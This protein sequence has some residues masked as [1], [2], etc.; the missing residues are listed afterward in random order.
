MPAT[1]SSRFSLLLTIALVSVGIFM[2]GAFVLFS[3]T[4]VHGTIAR[5]INDA[6]DLTSDIEPPPLY[7]IEAMVTIHELDRALDRAP[8]LARF[9]QLKQ[10][11]EASEKEWSVRL[12]THQAAEQQAF[13]TLTR[14]AHDFFA[15]VERELMPMV[16]RNDQAGISA[17]LNGSLTK[18]FEHHH[19]Q[20]LR[21]MK[22]LGE[23]RR[24]AEDRAHHV[25]WVTGSIM[26]VVVIALL[27]VGQGLVKIR[28]THQR[29]LR[30]REAHFRQLSEASFEG[31]GISENGVLVDANP[32]LVRMLGYTTVSDIIG[33]KLS[34]FIA[35]SCLSEFL[36]RIVA[37]NEQDYEVML[38]RLDGSEIYAEVRPRYCQIEDRKLR[39]SSIRDITQRKK[40]EQELLRHRDHLEEL[41]VER[42]GE[43]ERISKEAERLQHEAESARNGAID[44][45]QEARRM[46]VSYLNAK[47]AA[48]AANRAK[49]EF[50]ASM[51][52][53]IRTP[54]NAVLGYAQL[55]ARDQRL[56]PDQLRAV[57]VINRSGSHL[58]ALISDILDMSR[59]ESGRST[60]HP[61]DFDLRDLLDNLKS[62]FLIRAR[63][64]RLDLSLDVADVLPQF[65]RSDQRMLRQIM[66]NLLSNAVK[67]TTRGSVEILADKVEGQ[68]TI[69]VRDSGPGIAAEDLAQLF[70]PFVQVRAGRGQHEGSGLGLAISRGFARTIGG[71]IMAASEV[72]H[73]SNFT[74]RIP[75]VVAE[76]STRMASSGREVIGLAPGSVPPRIL[77]A[78]DH[79]D[80]QRL[81]CDLLGAAGLEVRAVHDGAAAV[82]CCRE[83]ILTWCGWISTCPCWT[84]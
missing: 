45:L 23:A 35:Q 55:L 21:M 2:T 27:L 73:G 53:E 66:M 16:Q 44:A 54:L 60:A 39:V 26:V 47:D 83:G 59:I 24:N 7:L 58:L 80:N 43:L 41:I 69:S 18:T 72:G 28:M 77:I 11:Y 48:E 49:S 75:L 3:Q 17:A 51:S 37:Q 40:S 31:I 68:L 19:E 20:V 57:Q 63:D 10:R 6:Q 78:E 70:Q 4:G 56:A 29:Q 14:S 81:L 33:R 76:R 71:D 32:Q 67:F 22:L 13:A 5:E 15:A 79:L 74:V 82:E 61:E 64:K 34:D 8:S 1:L 65:V 38:R 12:R 62:L 9:T 30:E 50:L 84:D 36:T 25:E 42:T 46:E 52:H